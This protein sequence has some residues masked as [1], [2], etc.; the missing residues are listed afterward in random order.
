MRLRALCLAAALAAASPSG[1]SQGPDGAEEDEGQQVLFTGDVV[2]AA[3]C[4]VGAVASLLCLARERYQWELASYNRFSV[5]TKVPVQVLCVSGPLV[6]V[7]SCL[8]ALLGALLLMGGTR[9]V[10]YICSSWAAICIDMS[11]VL[12]DRVQQVFTNWIDVV[13]HVVNLFVITRTFRQLQTVPVVFITSGTVFWTV[14]LGMRLWRRVGEA[15]EPASSK[16][17]GNASP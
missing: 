14:V 16:R 7:S 17:H 12:Y 8:Y 5:A 15:R 4:A 3:V 2:G 9:E 6:L 1:F 13:I 10:F 11:F